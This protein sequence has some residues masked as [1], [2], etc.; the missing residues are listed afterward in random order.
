V[1][2]LIGREE[3]VTALNYIDA[4]SQAV[5]ALPEFLGLHLACA[6]DQE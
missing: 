5:W 3:L 4:L 2:R 6:D 1:S